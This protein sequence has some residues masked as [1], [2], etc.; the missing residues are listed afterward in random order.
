MW[1]ALHQEASGDWDGMNFNRKCPSGESCRDEAATGD[2]FYSTGVT[3]LAVLAFLGA[4]HTPASGSHADA[5]ARA[6][7]HLLTKQ[8]AEGAL[9][10]Q[11]QV[12]LYNHSIATWALCETFALT[13][14]DRTGRAAERALEYLARTQ[15][16]GGGWDYFPRVGSAPERND[17]SITGWAVLAIRSA[18]VAGLRVAPGMVAKAREFLVRRT[19]ERTGEIVYAERAPGQD[20]RGAGLTA[21]GLFGRT[22]LGPENSAVRKLGI[23]RLVADLPDLRKYQTA[24]S[25]SARKEIAFSTEQNLYAWH[26]GA[27]ATFLIGGAAWEAWNGAL[28][29]LL[30][31]RQADDGHRRG[32]WDAETSYIGREGGR[33]F[34]TAIN[35]LTLEIYYRFLSDVEEEI[36]PPPDA[37]SLSKVADLLGDPD[38]RVRLAAV[39]ALSA[40]G[41][42]PVPPRLIET[43]RR[44]SPF[45]KG[46]MLQWIARTR[47]RSV[48]PLLLEALEDPSDEVAEGALR[49]LRAFSGRE[50]GRDPNAWKEWAERR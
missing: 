20:R 5:V 18:Q 35:V 33:V 6:V 26:A 12:N 40:A 9:S 13:G 2:S 49:G 41:T 3:G 44:E 1:L 39:R 28:R 46:R 15:N 31:R 32:S 14:D 23:D 48:I 19:D 10:S 4:G 8:S 43:V 17:A 24:Q 45:L 47:D 42:T 7:N 11:L 25:R 34:A 16:P 27:L 37:D 50:L 21:M 36:A 22:I 30:I 38:L 29:D